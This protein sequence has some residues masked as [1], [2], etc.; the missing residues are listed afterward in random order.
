MILEVGSTGLGL[1]L[2]D[3]KKRKLQD[4]SQGLGLHSRANVSAPQVRGPEGKLSL[5]VSTDPVPLELHS[6]QLSGSGTGLLA[7]RT[8]AA[9]SVLVWEA[10]G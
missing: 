2:G 4:D 7:A 6:R 8:E 10:D 3:A 1:N 5:C 9:A